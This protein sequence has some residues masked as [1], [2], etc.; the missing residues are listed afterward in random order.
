[1][2][3]IK[4]CLTF[5]WFL[6]PFFAFSLLDLLSLPILALLTDIEEGF[7]D[8]S[9]DAAEIKDLLLELFNLLLTLLQSESSGGA[10]GKDG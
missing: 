1:M 9:F 4:S 2:S 8:G 3:D 6:I 10:G 7:D 5:F